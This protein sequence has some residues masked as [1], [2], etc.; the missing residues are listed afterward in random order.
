MKVVVSGNGND[1]EAP[2]VPVFGRCPVFVFVDTDTLT[3]EALPNPAV[4]ASGGAGIQAAQEVVSRGV[5]AVITG[6]VGPNAY[7]VLAA[8]KVPVFI[9]AGD[10]VGEAVKAYQ[11][12]QLQSASSATGPAH[13][14]MGTMRV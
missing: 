6:N 8:A 11:A 14:G 9:F 5:Q 13:A 12:G 3:C 2:F 10:T 4:A 1:L 7:Q